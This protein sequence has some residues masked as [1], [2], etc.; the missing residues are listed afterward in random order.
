MPELPRELFFPA[1]A[2]EE[3]GVN[4]EDEALRDGKRSSQ[5]ICLTCGVK[6]ST[7]LRRVIGPCLF[8]DYRLKDL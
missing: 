3:C 1:H 6:I 7:H 8:V 2:R 5:L 4:L